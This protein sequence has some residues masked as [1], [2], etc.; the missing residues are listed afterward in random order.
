VDNSDFTKFV[1]FLLDFKDD[2]VRTRTSFCKENIVQNQNRVLMIMQII[3]NWW[4]AKMILL[5]KYCLYC[6]SKII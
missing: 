4:L 6:L 2:S 3:V 1:E 5:L